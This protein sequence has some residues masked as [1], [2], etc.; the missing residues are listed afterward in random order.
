MNHLGILDADKKAED[1]QHPGG[2]AEVEAH[3]V[4]MS[5]ARARPGADDHL[6]PGQVLHELVYQRENRCPP[7]V[8]K[9]LPSNFDDVGLGQ[10]LNDRLLI[11][12]SHLGVIGE[13]APDQRSDQL[14]RRLVFHVITSKLAEPR[15][16]LQSR[17][18]L[19]AITAITNLTFRY[20]EDST[21]DDD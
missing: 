8:D 18:V 19:P 5:G 3:A 6:V 7:A 17:S 13:A 14:A 4:C 15:I 11:D 1:A 2:H 9:A 16:A 21:T 10:D 12:R 20:R